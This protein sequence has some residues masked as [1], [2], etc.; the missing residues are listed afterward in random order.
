MVKI[1]NSTSDWNITNLSEDVIKYIERVGYFGYEYS[2]HNDDKY[3]A[4]NT[5]VNLE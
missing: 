1:Y 3:W 2:G 5:R 4:C